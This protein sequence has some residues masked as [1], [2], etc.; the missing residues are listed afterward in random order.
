MR[1]ARHK[2]PIMSLGLVSPVYGEG[3]EAGLCTLKIKIPLP[4]SKEEQSNLDA[5]SASITK[6]GGNKR[7][8]YS[9]GS[10]TF[11]AEYIRDL[12]WETY[13]LTSHLEPAYVTVNV[14]YLPPRN[15]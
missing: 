9:L 8:V 2:V 12:S 5:M 10:V 3:Y 11:A 1:T 6:P 7:N 4:I 13:P 15:T 14:D